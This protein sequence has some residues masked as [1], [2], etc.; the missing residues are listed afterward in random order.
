MIDDAV[1]IIEKL[2][3]KAHPE[4]GY[5]NEI[6]RS[7]E[8]YTG[9]NISAERNCGTSIYFLLKGNDFSSFHRLKYDEIWHFYKG[10]PISVVMLDQSGI[11]YKTLGTDILNNEEPQI[12]IPAG[13]WFGGYLKNNDS[14]SLIGCTM[15]PGF[16]YQDF[17]LAKRNELL[18]MYPDYKEI[19]HK[20]TR[21]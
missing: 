1:R 10:S 7:S 13:T 19:I 15:S 12:I 16:D 3:L 21:E 6:Y 9:G 17:E 11:K 5:F 18:T 14:Y 4:G 20:L 8:V 2:E